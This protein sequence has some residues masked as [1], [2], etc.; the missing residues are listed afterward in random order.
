MRS[1]RMGLRVV[2]QFRRDIRRIKGV[3]HCLSNK[4]WPIGSVREIAI[5]GGK[6]VNIANREMRRGGSSEEDIDGIRSRAGVV[7][8]ALCPGV[9][10][11]MERDEDKLVSIKGLKRSGSRGCF[12]TIDATESR[13]IQQDMPAGG[14]YR[15]WDGDELLLLGDE[16]TAREEQRESQE[17][18]TETLYHEKL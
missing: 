2:R 10:G 18:F 11:R 7:V 1:E 12:G 3:R 16:F 17:I 6:E 5:R 9:R 14:T 8:K 4:V 15:R 13:E